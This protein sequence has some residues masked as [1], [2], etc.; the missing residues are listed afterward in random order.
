MLHR[1]YCFLHNFHQRIDSYYFDNFCMRWNSGTW[2][3]DKMLT[4][5]CYRTWAMVRSNFLG[6]FLFFSDSIPYFSPLT[7]RV[8]VMEFNVWI[9][10]L[11]LP[12]NCYMLYFSFWKKISRKRRKTFPC[13]RTFWSNLGIIWFKKLGTS[14]TF[15]H[16]CLYVPTKYSNHIQRT[17][18]GQLQQ[19]AEN[20]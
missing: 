11:N 9:F 4:S 18:A 7:S 2:R 1:Y 10:L 12:C 19:N 14:N 16:L 5:L 3:W 6:N 17:K 15:H 13:K 8:S 20:S